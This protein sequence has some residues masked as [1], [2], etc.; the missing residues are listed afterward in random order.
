[1]ND[2]AQAARLDAASDS[3][4]DLCAGVALLVSTRN[5]TARKR[6][7]W[8]VVAEYSDRLIEAQGVIQEHEDTIKAMRVELTVQAGWLKW[9][10]RTGWVLFFA[11]ALVE[12]IVTRWF[13]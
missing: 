13:A 1:M 8:S 11:G 7:N 6:P 10:T 4:P 9:W 3:E 5:S 12:L 2:L